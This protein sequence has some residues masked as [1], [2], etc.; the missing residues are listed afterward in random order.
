MFRV[1]SREYV[2]FLVEALTNK[3]ASRYWKDQNQI[4]GLQ[5]DNNYLEEEK[6]ILE[7]DVESLRTLLKGKTTKTK[8]EGK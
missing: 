7:G 3:A 1:L 4:I 6:E 5:L 8:K 2:R